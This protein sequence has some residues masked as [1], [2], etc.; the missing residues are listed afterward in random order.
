[1]WTWCA[2][3]EKRLEKRTLLRCK[4]LIVHQLFVRLYVVKNRIFVLQL[5]EFKPIKIPIFSIG[6]ATFVFQQ[7]WEDMQK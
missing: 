7:Q 4:L 6:M 5:Q 3:H 1:M 2:A